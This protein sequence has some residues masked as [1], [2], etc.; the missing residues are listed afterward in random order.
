MT[1]ETWKPVVGYEGF[2][3]V[4]NHGH[5]RSD[6][7]GRLLRLYSRKPKKG[8]TC[9]HAVCLYR[10]KGAG[11]VFTVHR[12]VAQAFLPNALNLP[13]INHKDGNGLNNTQSNLE[14]CTAKENVWHAMRMG[15]HGS[16]RAPKAIS[17][18]GVSLQRLVRYN[19]R[20]SINGKRISIGTYKTRALAE[21]ALANFHA[22]PS[23][24]IP[25]KL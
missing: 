12:L 4:S 25:V 15:H 8:R 13:Q 7:S 14:W 11:R 24:P 10:G 5:V 20:L 6:A 22:D 19:A 23:I 21:Q 1:N 18:G 2:Y 17:P 9:Y 16:L 3:S